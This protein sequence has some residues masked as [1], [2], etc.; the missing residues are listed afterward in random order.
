MKH[1]LRVVSVIILIVMLSACA[2]SEETEII[3]EWEQT[4]QVMTFGGAEFHICDALSCGNAL[5]LMPD[6]TT[7]L[8]ENMERYVAHKKQIEKDYDCTITIE[9]G[10][11]SE[12]TK[13]FA[14]GLNYGN[15]LNFRVKDMY[16]LWQAGYIVDL[17]DIPTID[18]HSGKYGSDAILDAM[19]WKGQTVGVYANWW[20]TMTPNFSDGIMYNPRIIQELGL[21][22]PNELH[23]Q[24]K[25][26]WN[27]LTAMGEA[28]VGQKN[29]AGEDMYLSVLNN[30]FPRM[31]MLSNGGRYVKQNADGTYVFDA[32][33]DAA[34]EAFTYCKELDSLGCLKGGSDTG[35]NLT[36]FVEGRL[37]MICEYSCQGIIADDGVVGR[38][39]EEAYSWTYSPDGP[40][41]KENEFGVISLENQFLSPTISIEDYDMFGQF[42]ELYFDKLYDEPDTWVDSYKSMN[43]FD[44][45]SADCFF[46]KYENAI[47]DNV[48]F[49]YNTDTVFVAIQD[50][51]RNG[52]SAAEIMQKTAANAQPKLDESLNKN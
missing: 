18:L 49:M 41:S 14:S 5:L 30:Y 16:P 42:M 50:A 47:F 19:T 2:A 15:M 44:S 4:E 36:H 11:A 39:M 34:L 3:P 10:S 8:S 32:D 24:G 43:F 25:W 46:T 23:E 33:S 40:R 1:F 29:D 9:E 51:G 35:V 37:I 21:T 26:N 27:A 28:V 38:D 13:R 17:N 45:A 31:L 7:L 52:T 6:E 12:F 20:G 48:I 22:D